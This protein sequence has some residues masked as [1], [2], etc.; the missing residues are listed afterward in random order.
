V[1]HRVAM[2]IEPFTYIMAMMMAM[3][4]NLTFFGS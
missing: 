4:V 2:D 3:R 1:D